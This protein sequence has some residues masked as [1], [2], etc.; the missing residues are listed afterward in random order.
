MSGEPTSDV[1]TAASIMRTAPSFL[2]HLLGMNTLYKL[3]LSW[4]GISLLLDPSTVWQVVKCIERANRSG[5]WLALA[6][7]LLLPCQLAAAPEHYAA[8]FLHRCWTAS[9]DYSEPSEGPGDHPTGGHDRSS[10][11]AGGSGRRLLQSTNKNAGSNSNRT[12]DNGRGR[13]EGQIVL[14][15]AGDPE[16]HEEKQNGRFQCTWHHVQG[17][18]HDQYCAKTVKYVS[19][20]R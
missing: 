19:M 12:S 6:N 11:G 10:D 7:G 15:P 16:T 4:L 2:G 8:L 13:R 18:V 1:H 17:Y 5:L 14:S 20:L 3:I 9:L